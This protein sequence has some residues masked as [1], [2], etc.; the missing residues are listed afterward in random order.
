M[1]FLDIFKT[2]KTTTKPDLLPEQQ[3]AMNY[4]LNY[5]KG[6]QTPYSGDFNINSDYLTNYG[7]ELKSDPYGSLEFLQNL[8]ANGG[9]P[10]DQTASFAKQRDVA[11][12]AATRAAADVLSK[13]AKSGAAYSSSAAGAAAE[14]AGEVKAQSEA[15]ILQQEAKAQE[16]ARQRQIAGAQILVQFK[17]LMDQ[18]LLNAARLDMAAKQY[19]AGM[20]YEEFKRM[21]PDIYKVLES[22]WGRNVDFYSQTTPNG[23]GNLLNFAGAVTSVVGNLTGAKADLAKADAY[24]RLGGDAF[25]RLGGGAGGGSSTSSG[26]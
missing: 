16:A 26:G 1:G 20:N 25:A 5:A 11:T 17:T 12:N 19:E 2:S 15:N 10:V 13:A 8:V 6:G 4:L 14:R 9:N 21:Y 7:N 24:S 18:G 23:L 22:I 3:D